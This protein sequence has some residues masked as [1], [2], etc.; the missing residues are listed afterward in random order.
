VGYVYVFRH[1]DDDHFK[2]GRT[3]TVEKRLKQLQTGSPKP[4][5]VFDVI[6][7]TDAKEGEK[8]LHRRLA[9]KCLI[10][11]NFELTPDEVREAVNQARSFLEELPRLKEEKSQLQQLSLVESSEEMRPATDELLDQGRRLLQIRADKA[12][13]MAEV[14]DLELEEERLETAIKLAIGAAKGID[15]VATWQT[16][17]GRRRFNPEWL[18]ANDPELYEAY[19]SYVP[20]FESARFKADD[21]DKYAAHQEVHRIRYFYLVEGVDGMT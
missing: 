19:L 3:A 18:K 9:H 4:L 11:E 7:T 21:P 2:I 14:A 10:G 15:C 12:R 6:E 5:T 8:F 1:G 16:G 13:R 20:K 17:D